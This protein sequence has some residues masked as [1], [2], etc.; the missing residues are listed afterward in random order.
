MRNF[1]RLLGGLALSTVPSFAAIASRELKWNNCG[2]AV[3][4]HSFTISRDPIPG[5]ASVTVNFI[6]T[7]ERTLQLGQS[8]EA[9]IV[10]RWGQEVAKLSVDP[11]KLSE[12]NLDTPLSCPLEPGTYHYRQNVIFPSYAPPDTSRSVLH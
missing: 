4:F 1:S 12:N 3:T 6:A 11:C 8:A 2:S 9:S 10:D 5:G 7:L